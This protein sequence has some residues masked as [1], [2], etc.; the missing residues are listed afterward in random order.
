MTI[1]TL[2]LLQAFLGKVC[3]IFTNPI[4]RTFSETTLQEHFVVQV[5]GVT[6]DGILAKN[7]KENI[8]AFFNWTNIILIQEELVLSQAEYDRRIKAEVKEKKPEPKV[9][10]GLPFVD[11]RSLKR[12]INDIKQ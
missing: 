9:D 2:D 3:T 6:Q 11:I 7:I 12:V 10:S 4:N 5:V 8:M 1:E